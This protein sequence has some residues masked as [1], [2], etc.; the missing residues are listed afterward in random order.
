MLGALLMACAGSGVELTE[1]QSEHMPDFGDPKV[2]ETPHCTPPRLNTALEATQGQM[3]GFFSQLPYKCHQNRV[4]SV[5][6]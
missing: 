4:A 1:E 3:D 5:G 2:S 6:D